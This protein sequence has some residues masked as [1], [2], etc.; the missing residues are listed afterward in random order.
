MEK[1]TLNLTGLGCANCAA[2]I[3]SRSKSLAGADNVVLDFSRSRLTFESKGDADAT[4]QAIKQIVLDL[5]PDVVVSVAGAP[6]ETKA[7][8]QNSGLSHWIHDK[9]E[10]A[11][12]FSSLALFLI[13][14]IIGSDSTIALPFFLVAY[15]LSGYKVLHK[16]FRNIRRGEIFDENFLMSLATFGA[17]AIGEYPEAVAVMIFYE[18]GEY[19][20]DLAVNRSKR[21]ISS[22]M[23]IRPDQATVLRNGF[24]MSVSP[25]SVSL[26][27]TLMV[28]PGERVPLDGIIIEGSSSI[29]TSALT[30]ESVPRFITKGDDVLSGSVILSGVVQVK[31][32]SIYSESTVARILS[33]V[34]NATANKAP[35]E[36][37]ITKFARYYTPAVVLFA[38]GL[39]LVPSLLF[40]F[41]QFNTWLYR[42]LIFLVISCPCAL[43]VSVPLGFFSG[44]GNASKHGILVKGSNY[45]EAL[46][47][48]DTVVFD[49]TGTLTKGKFK[50]HEIYVANDSID[51]G[52]L[53]KLAA[54]AESHSN[55]PI[56]KSILDYTGDY[57]RSVSLNKIEEVSGK[58]VI[59][60]TSLG[61]I[62]AGNLSLMNENHI[63]VMPINS[64]HTQ[65][66]IALDS[67]YQGTF[68]VRDEIKADAFETVAAL[69][70]SQIEVHMLTGDRKEAAVSVSAELG[71]DKVSS[72]LLPENKY[73]IVDALIRSGK[74]VG[75]VGD[76]INDAPVL[77]LASVGI[78]MGAIGSDAA[79]E[80]SDVV[81]MTDEPSKIIEAIA[82][83]KKTKS[84]VTQ[85]IVF[86]LGA[87]LLIMALG[88]VGLSSMWMAIFA[89]VGVALI[90]VLNS[91]RVLGFKPPS[92]AK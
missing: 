27:E 29:D 14:I 85:N 92:V 8:S 52:Q 5:E 69:H 80:A 81:L 89:D 86:A 30:G 70:S 36:N 47:Q 43:V 24:W 6:A 18:I 67:K 35:T 65:V 13:G 50:V 64:P 62:I 72:E 19:F 74:N 16:S 83:S 44:I 79:I 32:T 25:E 82:I 68:E 33:L 12:L 2:K 75:F 48:I 9:K 61:K 59:V 58:G 4:I 31:A 63:D 60:E 40:G 3:E 21:A 54:I 37:F 11:R 39:V 56:A 73:E 76:G 26:G 78:S 20:Q 22:L 28:K 51:R 42:G 90:A 87:K 57:D 66:H 1:V 53:S 7:T 23:D 46:S 10:V 77:A 17:I 15:L 49:K 45:L 41:D 38:L 91:T 34:E 84:V 71:I 55:H 88:T